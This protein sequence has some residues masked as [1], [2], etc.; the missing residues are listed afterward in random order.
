MIS[1]WSS[2][3]DKISKSL[4]LI[5]FRKVDFGKFPISEGKEFQIFGPT[6]RKELRLF[7]S[8]ERSVQKSSLR[9]DRVGYECTSEIVVKALLILS[10]AEL[11]AMSHMILQR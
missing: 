2:D 6:L 11:L 9:E 7:L 8:L 1:R 10:G 4:F 5:L 3:L